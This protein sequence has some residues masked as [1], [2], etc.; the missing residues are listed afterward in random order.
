MCP[1]NLSAKFAFLWVNGC[2]CFLDV[3][4]DCCKSSVMFGL[5]SSKDEDV[6]HLAEDTLKTSEELTHTPSGT[7]NSKQEFIEAIVPRRCD[8]GGEET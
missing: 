1:R 5:V 3:S 7:R 4:K 8:E 2:T 6:V